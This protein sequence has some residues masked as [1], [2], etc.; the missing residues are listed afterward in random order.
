MIDILL[1]S[2]KQTHTN[3]IWT[4]DQHAVPLNSQGITSKFMSKNYTY[5]SL[6]NNK[7]LQNKHY[8]KKKIYIRNI[9]VWA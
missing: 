9:G 5:I 4:L 7:Y 8:N 3:T 6:Q 2:D 1:P